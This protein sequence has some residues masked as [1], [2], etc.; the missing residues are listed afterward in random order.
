MPQAIQTQQGAQGL[1]IASVDPHGIAFELG[2]EPGD[3]VVS[4]DGQNITDILD[5][6]YGTSE[7]SCTLIV[8][9]ADGD[10]LWEIDVE[11]GP[12]EYLGI[13]FADI[14]VN[15]LKSCQNDCV[16]CFVQQMPPGLR[17]SLYDFDDDYRMSVS[18]GNY[19]TLT[20]VSEEEFDRILALRVS[21]LYI[22]VHA[23]DTQV[24][25]QMM[26][27]PAAGKLPEQLHRLVQ[28][29]I[30]LHTQ[31][32]LV[33]GYNDGETLHQTV[34]Q[35]A[36]SYPQVQ[37]IG[38]VPVGLTRYRGQLSPLRV[39][40]PSECAGILEEGQIWQKDLRR[41]FGKNLLYFADEFYLACGHEIPTPEE[42][43]G[44]EQLENGIGM[45]SAFWD[46]LTSLLD[47][48]DRD[49]SMA[50]LTLPPKRHLITGLLAE[51]FLRK[52]LA[53]VQTRVAV[54]GTIQIHS[55]R[56]DFFGPAITVS[57]LVTA[58][59]IVGQ[60]KD[61]G[62]EEF[63]IPRV[64]LKA[65]TNE[66]LDGHSVCW[67]EEQLNSPA[68]IVDSSAAGFLEAIRSLSKRRIP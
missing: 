24:R 30:V 53:L 68:K 56:N 40:T 6:Q 57:G 16:F 63:L 1:L 47:G 64:M 61:L 19:I 48:L 49:R 55:I 11:R 59:D 37:T 33:P 17:S 65:D 25:G 22:S 46:E 62:G 50:P 26:G 66:F 9:K 8:A 20:N 34:Q 2:I 13:S 54:S 51:P 32:V 60:L 38:V 45:L 23:W 42:Y 18:R 21:P 10:E 14:A 52:C 31:I 35:L 7:E 67:L 12:Y 4:V 15:G 44:F 39:L 43:D 28:A 36:L 5:Y 3:R 58:A 29:G 41:R 27:N